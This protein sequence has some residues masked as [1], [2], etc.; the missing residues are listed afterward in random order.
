MGRLYNRFWLV[1]LVGENQSS[2]D[3]K[4]AWPNVIQPF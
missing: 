1:G 3:F 4:G 2:F